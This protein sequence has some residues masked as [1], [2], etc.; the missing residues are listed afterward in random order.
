MS[1]KSQHRLETRKCPV[2]KKQ[3]TYPARN[4][5]CSFECGRKAEAERRQPPPEDAVATHR[6]KLE[7]RELQAQL[8]QALDQ[9]VFDSR[10]QSFVS[11]VAA[12]PII[13]PDWV[14]TP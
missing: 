11:D 10:Y 4:E 7:A 2:C 8:R 9:R 1:N 6:K 3:K 5:T 12:R 14:R 13:V